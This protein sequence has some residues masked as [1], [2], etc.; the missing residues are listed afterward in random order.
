MPNKKISLVILNIT[1]YA[2]QCAGAIHLY[3]HLIL[4]DR[5]NITIDNCAEWN[6]RYL[7]EDIE[8]RQPLTLE[9]AKKLDRIDGHNTYQRHLRYSLEDPSYPIEY[10]TTDR[11]D[12][13]EQIENFAI[14]K[15]KEL[16]LDCPFISL[17]EGDRY[18][19][20]Y[21]GEVKKT[22]IFYTINDK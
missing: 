4:C 8:L 11:F 12:T 6:V 16:N 5:E 14:A 2:G 9:L 7:G 15:W 21:G 17:Y 22:K 1:S 18:D 10:S 20:N 19:S 3:G 13:F